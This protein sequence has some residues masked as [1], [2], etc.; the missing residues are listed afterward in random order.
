VRYALRMPRPSTS[1]SSG[2]GTCPSSSTPLIMTCTVLAAP[3]LGRK[4]HNLQSMQQS[5]FS[6]EH[7]RLWRAT[8]RRTV[9][10]TTSA[11]SQPE[12]DSATEAGPGAEVR[13]EEGTHRRRA[14]AWHCC[15]RACLYTICLRVRAAQLPA[16]ASSGVR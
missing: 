11:C 9:M 3:K 7:E 14:R 13:V 10:S 5:E 15:L 8:R 6:P 2:Y 12:G 1:T 4:R 16:Q